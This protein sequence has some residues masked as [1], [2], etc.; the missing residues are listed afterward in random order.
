[1]TRSEE[2]ATLFQSWETCAEARD[3]L[4]F[5]DMAT[6]MHV[7]EAIE[8]MEQTL[9][10]AWK[11][12]M[13]RYGSLKER[14]SKCALTQRPTLEQEFFTKFWSEV[15]KINGQFKLAATEVVQAHRRRSNWI[16]TM[17]GRSKIRLADG[18]A[19][20]ATPENIRLHSHICLEYARKNAEG[21]KKIAEA[22]DEAY[23]NEAGRIVFNS[24]WRDQSG[25]AA[26]LHS[27][28]LAEL[29]AV[30]LASDER[31]ESRVA[32]DANQD[33][34]EG[35][36]NEHTHT[37]GKGPLPGLW[38]SKS[39]LK[40]SQK[41]PI[42]LDVLYRP[43]GLA[44]GH[45]F[46]HNCLFKAVIPGLA[47]SSGSDLLDIVPP[48]SR[49]P[50]CRQ[51]GVFGNATSLPALASYLQKQYPEY[52]RERGEEEREEDRNARAQILKQLEAKYRA[53]GLSYPQIVLCGSLWP[54][55]MKPVQ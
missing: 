44:C 17:L 46:C 15:E 39:A 6:E 27:P 43:I 29:E 33:R 20:A 28:L 55:R 24:M 40:E 13:I 5:C 10:R 52:W 53:M 7:A 21:I 30:I 16:T 19:V 2:S 1:M 32:D 4:V 42:C 36:E 11:G 34:A 12:K 18:Q 51:M 26:F 3:I 22:H 35:G 50:Q 41:C 31:D 23:G 8:T 47:L 49:C 45:K 14:L 54:L 38:E 9:P 37:W 48:F 25:V